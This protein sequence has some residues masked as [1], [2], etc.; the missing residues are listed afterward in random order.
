MKTNTNKSTANLKQASITNE[1]N[2]L[3]Y[4]FL[5]SLSFNLKFIHLVTRKF[6]YIKIKFS[7]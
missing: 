2:C 4:V 6:K 1:S 5:V 3:F 7:I